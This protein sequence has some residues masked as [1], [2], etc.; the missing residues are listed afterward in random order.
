MGWREGGQGRRRRGPGGCTTDHHKACVT[1]T[2][3]YV[4]GGE[5]GEWGEYVPFSP[6][7][8]PPPTSPSWR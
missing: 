4:L 1:V 2:R 6:P 7:P 3:L 5:G 8:F